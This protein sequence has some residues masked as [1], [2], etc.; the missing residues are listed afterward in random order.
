[1]ISS[2]NIVIKKC[3]YRVNKSI[4]IS[5]T[6]ACIGLLI[7]NMIT[8]VILMLQLPQFPPV[9][10][11]SRLLY[12]DAVHSASFLRVQCDMSSLLVSAFQGI[13]ICCML[14][15]SVYRSTYP[16]AFSPDKFRA[17]QMQIKVLRKSYL[18]QQCN[19]FSS[20]GRSLLF[21]VY[22]VNDHNQTPGGNG[23]QKY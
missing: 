8:C 1:M 16:P 14:M 4:I 9:S 20:T 7:H 18:S 11:L 12:H 13:L 2:R 19:P 15:R 17:A 6:V 22:K 21:S 3:I 10:S 5:I 23:K